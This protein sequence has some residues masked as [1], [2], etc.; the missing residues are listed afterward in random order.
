MN[1]Q[2]ENKSVTYIL[3]KLIQKMLDFI[4]LSQKLQL[5]AL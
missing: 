4:T 1:I 3:M 2:I 5:V